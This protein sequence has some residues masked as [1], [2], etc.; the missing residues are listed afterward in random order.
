MTVRSAVFNVS[1]QKDY[2]AWTNHFDRQ[3][4]FIKA[5]LPSYVFSR[6]V[7]VYSKFYLVSEEPA[8]PGSPVQLRSIINSVGFDFRKQELR[9]A[10]GGQILH[11]SLVVRHALVRHDYLFAPHC[12]F[13]IISSLY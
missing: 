8:A 4:S 1:G 2:P 5:R 6:Y 11:D 10:R 12:A 13:F 3:S 9:D 7:T